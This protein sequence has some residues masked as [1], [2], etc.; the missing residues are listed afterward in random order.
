MK[1]IHFIG[2]WDKITNA[3]ISFKVHSEN[4]FS[5]KAPI[6][7]ENMFAGDYSLDLSQENFGLIWNLIRIR[8]DQ[9][10]I[11]WFRYFEL[12]YL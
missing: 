11:S 10:N 8:R 5:I 3:A 4:V 6:C 1:Q 7:L 2:K 9:E 12:N